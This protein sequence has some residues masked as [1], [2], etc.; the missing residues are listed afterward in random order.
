MADLHARHAD[1]AEQ[2]VRHMIQPRLGALLGARTPPPLDRPPDRAGQAAGDPGEQGA[3][4]DHARPDGRDAD[5]RA[6]S[7]PWRLQVFRA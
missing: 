1:V 5:D 6:A 7:G 2:M 3:E 4:I